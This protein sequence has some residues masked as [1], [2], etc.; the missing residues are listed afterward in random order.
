M[1]AKC[2]FW[3]RMRRRVGVGGWERVRE[4]GRGGR[5]G[6]GGRL[7]REGCTGRGRKGREGERGSLRAG[8][9]EGGGKGGDSRVALNCSNAISSSCLLISRDPSFSFTGTG[10]SLLIANTRSLPPTHP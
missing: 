4:G 1:S 6:K 9:R 8:G 3:S 2:K 7:G 5:C 10:N